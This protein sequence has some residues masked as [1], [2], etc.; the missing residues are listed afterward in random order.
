ME[1]FDWKSSI[2][3]AKSIGTIVSLSGALVVTFYDGPALLNTI[4]SSNL[5]H[6]KVLFQQQF[7]WIIGGLLLLVDAVM[8]SVW[9]IIQV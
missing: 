5:S 7:N 4:S 1:K 8:S 2:G 6:N 9:L 3:L